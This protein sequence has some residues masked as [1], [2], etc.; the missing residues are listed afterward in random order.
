MCMCVDLYI[1]IKIATYTIHLAYI[2]GCIY[3]INIATYTSCMYIWESIQNKWLYIYIIYIY[4]VV[5][6]I[7]SLP[8]IYT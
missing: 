2:Y 3:I 4:I 7:Q 5:Y 1:I 8:H 6:Y